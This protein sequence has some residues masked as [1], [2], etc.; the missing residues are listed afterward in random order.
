MAPDPAEEAA[1]QARLRNRLRPR[2][3]LELQGGIG[4]L[5]VSEWNDD[6]TVPTPTGS[7]LLGF[8][9]NFTPTMG[10]LVRG[11]ALLGAAILDYSP[12]NDSTD[13]GSDGTVM[14]GGIIEAAPFFGPFGRFYLGPSLWAGYVDFG[15]DT[16]RAESENYRYGSAIFHLHSGPM[17][18]VGGTGGVV[19]G[20]EE[21]VD[22]TF[23][24]RLDLNPDHKTTLFLLFGVGFH[25]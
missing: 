6:V 19:V 15:T 8:R 22:I 14:V 21:Q 11:G 3:T 7:L 1:W 25:R 23:T 20:A 4:M 9:Q 13:H 18:G 17:Y 12:T 5:A 10:L 24:G 16:L 2:F